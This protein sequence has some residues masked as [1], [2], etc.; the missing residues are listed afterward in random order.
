MA[1]PAHPTVEETEILHRFLAKEGVA[2]DA[3]VLYVPC[4]IGRR[5]FALADRGYRVSAVDPNA[6][7]IEAVRARVPAAIR[8]RLTFLA[9]PWE[10][11]PGTGADERFDVILC[12]D[13]ALGRHSEAEDV[14]FLRRLGDHLVPEG[15]LVVDLLH[16]DFFAARPRPFAFHVLGNVEQHEFRSFDSLSGELELTWRFY[17]RDGESLRHRTD[18]SVRLRLFT[19]HEARELLEAAGWRVDGAWGGYGREPI[20]AERRKLVLLARPSARG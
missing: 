13:H 2:D 8:D 4:G 5:A 12:L 16:R 14:A 6:I 18:S 1:A 9:A 17:E 19:P 20:H 15:R 11:L 7:G 10:A 3:R